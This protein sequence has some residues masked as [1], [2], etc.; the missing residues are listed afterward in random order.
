MNYVI[1]VSGGVDSMVLLDALV[2]PNRR[3]KIG[4]WGFLQPSTFD[5]QSNLIVAHF[6]H[7][8][9]TDSREDEALVRRAAQHYGLKYETM[10]VELGELASEDQARKS[11]YNF[12]RQVCKKY[13]AQLLTAHHQ[14]DVL[15]TMLI[16]LIRGTGWRG[17]APMSRSSGLNTQTN[18]ATETLRPLLG[19]SKEALVAYAKKYSVMWREDSSNADEIY[20]RNYIRQRLIPEMVRRDDAVLERLLE[21]NHKAVD[22]K[23]E[24]ATELQ[25][26]YIKYQIADSKYVIPRYDLIMPPSSTAREAIYAILTQLDPDWHPLS[27]HI[28][29]VLHFVKTG[30]PAKRLEVTKGLTVQLT[31]REALFKK[32]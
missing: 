23:K 19:T 16:N 25:K 24:I 21:I 29:R 2:N 4:E 5:P 10:R 9:R 27:I 26:L 14:N 11:R 3:S 12:L 6:D 20:L 28:E 30:R 15:E 18:A 17:L 22:L 8:I 31:S 1:A 32:G 7:G 13:S